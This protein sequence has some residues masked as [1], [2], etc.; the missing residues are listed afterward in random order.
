MDLGSGLGHLSY[1]TL[2]HPA[3]NWDQLW[4]SLT[5]YLPAVKSRISPNRPFAVSL[6]LA[7]KSAEALA[8]SPDERQKLKEWWMKRQG[9]RGRDDGPPK[10]APPSP[11]EK[12]E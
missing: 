8:A 7:N 9:R 5:R 11:S 1:S 4:D 12:A 6:R 2:V 3:D 10:D